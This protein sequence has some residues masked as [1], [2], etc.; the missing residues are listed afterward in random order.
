MPERLDE[1]GGGIDTNLV[2]HGLAFFAIRRVDAN[3]DKFMVF[4]S[5]ADFIH[6]AGCQTS[7]TRDDDRFQSMSP[8]L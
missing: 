5:Q 4:K 7:L 1:F 3:L 8:S 2:D 6:Q